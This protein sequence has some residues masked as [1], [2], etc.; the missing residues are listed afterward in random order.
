[1]NDVRTRWLEAARL[2]G[3]DPSQV[4][5]CPVCL[6]GTLNVI[7]AVY[8]DDATR[9][10]RQLVCNKCNA[11]NVIVRMLVPSKGPHNPV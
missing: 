3:E 9:M 11:T 5:V 7:D 4:V 6:T 2:L 10:D 8:A 1:M